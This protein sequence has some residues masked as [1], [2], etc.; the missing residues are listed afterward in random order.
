MK[1]TTRLQELFHSGKAF[2]I[3]GGACAIH[4]KV[5]ELAGCECAYMSGGLTSLMVFGLPDAGLV[6]MTEMVEN[7][8]RMNSVIS[9]PLISDADQGYGNA[10]NV[11]RT[12]QSF[13][14]AG[15]AGIHIEDQPMPKRCGFVGG[16][17][18]ISLEEAEGKYRAAVDAKREMDKDFVIIARCEA[19]TAVGGSLG[20]VIKRLKAYKRAGADVLYPEGL[21][22]REEL[23]AVRAEVQGPMIATLNAF[24]P[25]VK[26]GELKGLGLAAA[27]FSELMA[28][29]ALETA[30]QAAHAF[31]A[32]GKKATIKYVP[33]RLSPPMPHFFDLVDFPK[34]VEWEKKYLP[35][36]TMGKY[37]GSVGLYDPR[38]SRRR[39]R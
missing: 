7:A 2:T 35:P 31:R 22:S 34:I 24:D 1:K 38:V 29:P 36:R 28:L 26:L 13:I 18:I 20:E 12:V 15:V 25:P 8:D 10:I 33:A 9:I 17:E 21:K 37:D 30:W 27:F 23:K 5:A 16:K 39:P 19:R 3:A 6:T 11:R 4:A 32:Q 14:Q